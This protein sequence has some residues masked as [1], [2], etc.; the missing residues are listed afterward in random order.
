MSDETKTFQE[1]RRAQ[2][3][4]GLDFSTVMASA[5]H[6]MKNSL[7]MLLHS[8]DELRQEIP[9]TV[10][11]SPR[12]N[13]LRYEAERVH[14]DLV[15]L[16]GLY[17]LDQDTLSAHIEE[18][19]LPDYLEAQIARHIP[20]LEGHGLIHEVICEPVSGYFDADLLAGVINNI[21]N[22]AIRYTRS[23]IRIS[24]EENEGFL[25]I[26]VADDGSGYPDTMLEAASA[27]SQAPID[28]QSGSTRLGL[29]FAEAVA[30]LHRDSDR[31][32]EVRIHNGG[33]LG[34]G[35]FEIWLP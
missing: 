13:T 35:I 2:G 20:L 15:Q 26:R 21:V 5:V 19:F 12:F 9:D 6:D 31:V 11:S 27:S 18:H 4:E 23:R 34:G 3:T 22:N 10:E 29:Y 16:L 14:G 28:F 17:R 7:G 8:L 32:G 30:R 25:V 24:A 33:T 1:G